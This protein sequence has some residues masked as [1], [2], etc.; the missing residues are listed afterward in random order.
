MTAGH[1]HIFLHPDREGLGEQRVWSYF[2]PLSGLDLERVAILYG[3]LAIDLD[4]FKV[5]EKSHWQGY[6]IRRKIT[7]RREHGYTE[8]EP[9]PA[10]N[11]EVMKT[12][13]AAWQ[14]AQHRNQKVIVVADLLVTARNGL[15]ALGGRPELI[16][17][18]PESRLKRTKLPLKVLVTPNPVP[19]RYNW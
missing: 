1:V 13:I 3:D 15:I 5:V 6:D 19:S 14:A 17:A 2:E 11:L 8:L 16:S 4:A 18:S 12:L 7:E 10:E 9:L